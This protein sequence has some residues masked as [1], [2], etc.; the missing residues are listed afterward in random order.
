M[1][2]LDLVHEYAN[3]YTG[4]DPVI[5][6][7]TGLVS[8]HWNPALSGIVLDALPFLTVMR[9]RVKDCF[10][11]GVQEDAHEAFVKV[12]D[13][14]KTRDVT[15]NFFDYRLEQ[16]I[17]CPRYN[18]SNKSQ[19]TLNF[20]LLTWPANDGSRLDITH[21][22]NVQFF[23]PPVEKVETNCRTG[24]INDPSA[25]KR[26]TIKSL[27]KIL[28]VQLSRFDNYGDKLKN[29]ANIPTLID[30]PASTGLKGRYQLV[31]VINHHGNTVG[32]G[33]Y[34]AE[35][36]NNGEWY[37]ADDSVISRLNRGFTNPSKAAYILI[38]RLYPL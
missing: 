6:S 2:H 16:S 38:Y 5:R 28:L 10:H 22:M 1:V 17:D 24:G 33:H 4:S 26:M 11:E 14:L 30:V 21:M 13:T 29:I 37:S 27:P 19:E 12:I 15:F 25:T 34:T 9:Q 7:F 36:S 8:E 23:S 20:V 32:S 35:Y 18:L 3:R 31:A